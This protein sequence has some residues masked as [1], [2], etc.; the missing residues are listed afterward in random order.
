[1]LSLPGNWNH[2]G[3]WMISIGVLVLMGPGACEQDESMQVSE[4]GPPQRGIGEVVGVDAQ[5]RSW[6]EGPV[7]EQQ[8]PDDPRVSIAKELLG[9]GK[10]PEA[11]LVFTT[12]L[13]ENSQ[14]ARARFLRAIAIQKQKHYQRALAELDVAIASGQA[15]PERSHG[16]HFRGWCLYH[17]GR[18]G[19]AG[20]AFSAHVEAHPEEGDS[21]F[22][23]GVV[24]MELGNLPEAQLYFERAIELQRGMPSRLREI[25][26]AHARLGDV[27]LAFNRLDLARESYH[28]AVIRWPDHHEAWAKL[29]RVLDRLDRPEQAERARK[30]HRNARLRMGRS[31]EEEPS[32]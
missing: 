17:L 27:H 23:L 28:Q 24:A 9:G 22:G 19:E 1:V 30:E 12:V 3:W 31:V 6:R 20:E 2:Q 8:W 11:E 7:L 26:K 5:G 15:F 10:Y 29:A 21:H 32:D 4:P 18:T 16:E 13:S 25:A 14:V